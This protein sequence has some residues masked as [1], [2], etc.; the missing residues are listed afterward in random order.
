MIKKFITIFLFCVSISYADKLYDKYMRDFQKLDKSQILVMKEI[1][2]RV[3]PYGLVYSALAIAWQE[4]NFGKWSINLQDPSCGPF[5]QSVFHYMRKY[6][7][8]MT[9]F[10]MNK[11]CSELI[12][13]IDLSVA[14]F[15]SE[16]ESWELVH[17]KRWNK[18]DYIYRSYNA[19]NNWNS[20]VAKNY[21]LK[22]RTRIRV[23]KE[24]LPNI[25]SLS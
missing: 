25:N 1:Y 10:N 8:K 5:Q 2:K 3:E 6:K 23:L 17:R 11:V 13:N 20:E 14:T 21:S 22:I 18:W 9:D 16:I 4:S 15:I 24:M 12:F 19:G 7:L